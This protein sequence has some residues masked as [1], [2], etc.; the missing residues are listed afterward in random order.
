MKNTRIDAATHSGFNTVDTELKIV[1]NEKFGKYEMVKLDAGVPHDPEAWMN[2]NTRA[3][4]AEPKKNDWAKSEV[5]TVV[6]D[7]FKRSE[8]AAFA[9]VVEKARAAA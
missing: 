1:K 5:M 9:A 4:C 7:R 2:C 6:T 8:P 3:D